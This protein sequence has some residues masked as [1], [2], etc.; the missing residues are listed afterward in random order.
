MV[1]HRSYV[2]TEWNYDIIGAAQFCNL[3]DLG[4]REDHYLLDIGCG[5]LRAGKLLI[6]YL[7][8]GHYYGIEPEVWLVEEAVDVEIGQDVFYIKHPCFSSNPEFKLSV[9]NRQFDYLLAHSIFSHAAITQV[10]ACFDEAS[11]VMKDDGKF[12][13]TFFMGEE[14]DL[15]DNWRYPDNVLY[16]FEELEEVAEACGLFLS[17]KVYPHPSNQTWAVATRKGR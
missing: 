12:L 13:F 17:I 8:P 3:I 2:G 6:P 14:S 7:L 10:H 11:R 9:F 4:L 5:S 1:K 16:A 15:L